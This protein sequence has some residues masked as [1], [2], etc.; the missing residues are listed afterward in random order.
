[1]IGQNVDASKVAADISQPDLIPLIHHFLYDKLH[2]HSDSSTAT[3]SLPLPFFDEPISVYPSAMATFYSPSDLCGTQ[4]MH[5]ECIHTV[6]S[7][8]HSPGRYDCV[9]VNMDSN[10]E[11]MRSLD[12]AS[13]Q[14]F[15]SF[16]FYGK[17]YPCALVH[18]Y[19]HI[20]DSPDVLWISNIY[21]YLYNIF[22]HLFTK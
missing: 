19:S 16:R 2:P 11:G 15:F 22:F 1:M 10:A 17:F 7:W 6:P 3:S 8:R 5:H 12:V 20:G 4:G 21:Q 18:Q 14:L 13:V 9:F